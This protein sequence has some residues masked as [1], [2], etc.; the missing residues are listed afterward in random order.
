MAGFSKI[1]C[2]GGLGGFMGADGI[3]PIEVQIWVGDSSRQWMEARYFRKGIKPIGD[4]KKII[5]A[6]P[7]HP[8]NLLDAC[9][10]FYPRAFRDCPSLSKVKRQLRGIECLDFDQNQDE[11][12][13]DWYRLREEARQPML[14]INIFEA[15]LVRYNHPNLIQLKPSR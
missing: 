2:I 4:L 6:A 13:E 8:D 9:I 12:P 7:D 14:S 10:A 1:Y 15:N 5:P 11:I 3:N